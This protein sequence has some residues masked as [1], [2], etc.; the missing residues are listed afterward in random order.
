MAALPGG[1]FFFGS[2]LHDSPRRGYRS[3]IR[4]QWDGTLTHF[5]RSGAV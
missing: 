5:R 3:G 2:R 1:H 4:L